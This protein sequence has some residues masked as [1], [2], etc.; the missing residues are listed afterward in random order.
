V[1]PVDNMSITRCLLTIV[2]TAS[3]SAA[4]VPA[5]TPKKP[6]SV[7]GA[8]TNSVTKA[9]V[10]SAT[11]TKTRRSSRVPLNNL[12]RQP[13]Q[14]HS[15]FLEPDSQFRSEEHTSELQSLT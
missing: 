12:S 9:P 4:Q 1:F 8:V 10:K 13:V 15:K 3:L 11:V 7:A 6:G 5:T 14:C 2:L